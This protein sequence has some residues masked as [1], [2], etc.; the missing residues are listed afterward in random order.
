MKKLILITILLVIPSICLGVND[1]CVHLNGGDDVAYIGELNTLEIWI[2]NDIDLLS[3]QFPLE[4]CWPSG[5]ILWA[6]NL[7]YGN[8]PPFNRHGDAVS[9]LILD[10]HI[11]SFDYISCDSFIFGASAMM[12]DYLP[13]ATSRLCYSL[14]F[15]IVSQSGHIDAIQIQPYNHYASN[16]WF[17]TRTNQTRFAP[18]FCGETVSSMDNPTAPPVTFDIVHRAQYICG[19]TDCS[20]GVDIDDVVY[21]INYIFAGGPAPCD[22]DDDLIPD[23]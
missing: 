7:G 4:V 8:S 11:E 20:G 2:A 1:I 6:W 9:N 21:L 19:D 23:C 16:N 17:F 22:P 15:G 13:P 12:G 3:L 5:D 10:A 14:Q 18:D